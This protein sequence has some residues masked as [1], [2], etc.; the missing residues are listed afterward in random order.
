MWDYIG[1][2]FLVLRGTGRVLLLLIHGL[3][4]L[5]VLNAKIKRPKKVGVPSDLL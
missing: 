5:I 3:G 2:C 4:F 1:L